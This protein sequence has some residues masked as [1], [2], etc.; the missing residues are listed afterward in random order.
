[1]SLLAESH[2]RSVPASLPGLHRIHAYNRVGTSNTQQ[3]VAA[4]PQHPLD[5]M[6]TRQGLPEVAKML[7]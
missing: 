1:M 4:E 2:G 6:V 3:A 7:V 5:S